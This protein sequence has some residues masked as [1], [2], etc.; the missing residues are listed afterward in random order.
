MNEDQAEEHEVRHFLK[1]IISHKFEFF[2]FEKD[3]T[4]CDI[5]LDGTVYEKNEIIFC[6]KCN[7]A[8]HQLCYGVKSIPLDSWY[9]VLNLLY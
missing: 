3:A 1:M 8:V 7:V 4:L 5:C 6:D 9:E 2:S